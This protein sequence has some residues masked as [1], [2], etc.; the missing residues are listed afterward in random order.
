MPATISRLLM[1]FGV[2]IGAVM[3]YLPVVSGIDHWWSDTYAFAFVVITSCLTV[4]AGR[5]LVCRKARCPEYGAAYTLDQLY[6]SITEQ[7]AEIGGE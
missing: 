4:A 5:I 2:L 6:A 3:V 7:R 1:C